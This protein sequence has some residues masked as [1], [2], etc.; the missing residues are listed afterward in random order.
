MVN[1][2]NPTIAVTTEMTYICMKVYSDS[3]SS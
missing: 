1:N 2:E 3:P